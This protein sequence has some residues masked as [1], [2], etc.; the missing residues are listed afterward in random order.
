MRGP[1]LLTGA[2]GQVGGEALPILRELGE[3]IAP[4]R[5][6]L[7]LSDP[8]AIRRFIRTTKPAWIV[9]PAAYT[10]VDKAESEPEAAR[11]INAIAPGIIGEEAAAIGAS[12]IHYST[13]YVFRG[14]GTEPWTESSPTGPLGV[15]GQTKLE[16]EQALARSGAQHFIF[17]TSWVYG[18]TGKNFLLTILRF[19]RERAELRIV[20]DQ[21]GAPTWSRDLAQ[22]AAHT[23]RRKDAGD[24]TVSSDVFHACSG[25]ATSWFGFAEEFLR[26]ARAHEPQTHFAQLTPIATAEYPTPAARPLNS[27]MNCTKLKAELG[28]VM[29][30]WQESLAQVMRQ[31]L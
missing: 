6:D 22:L 23:I 26:I 20:A 13:D 12:V 25:G 24:E 30:Q 3:V 9:N 19:A 28:F 1:I 5:S 2:N 7:D 27:R 10:A 21:I 31:V 17:R 15:Y 8:D 16:G 14:D 4:M 18:A 11:A 29:P